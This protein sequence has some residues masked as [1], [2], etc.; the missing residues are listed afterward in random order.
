MKIDCLNGP[1][2]SIQEYRV[3]LEVPSGRHAGESEK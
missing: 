3:V 2:P 1:F